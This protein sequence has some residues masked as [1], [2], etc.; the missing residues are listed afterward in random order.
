MKL[1]EV[2]G[3]RR[4]P[5]AAL[6]LAIVFAVPVV[7]AQ[8]TK[9]KVTVDDVDRTFTVRLPKGYDATRKYPVVILLHGMNQDADDMERLTRFNEL[10]DK[11]GIIAVYPAALHGRWNV[12]VRPQDIGMGIQGA[13]IRVVATRVAGIPAAVEGIRA[14]DSS[15]HGIGSQRKSTGALKPMM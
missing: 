14:V 13:D 6:C 3:L 4:A 15:S 9:E 1:M 12:G 10:A 8:E 5:V 2:Y 7:H 11:D